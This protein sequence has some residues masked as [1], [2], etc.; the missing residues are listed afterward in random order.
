MWRV[1]VQLS[2][3]LFFKLARAIEIHLILPGAMPTGIVIALGPGKLKSGSSS[4]VDVSTQ[5]A[6]KSLGS[7][8]SILP[9]PDSKNRYSM[10]VMRTSSS[11][12]LLAACAARDLICG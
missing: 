10:L 9:V 8:K 4:K 1:V 3:N 6:S 11:L 7:G 2:G 5:G 12:S